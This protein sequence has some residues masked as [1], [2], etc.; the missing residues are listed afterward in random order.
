NIRLAS[1][2]IAKKNAASTGRPF[3]R[4]IVISSCGSTGRVSESVARLS[5]LVEMDIFDFVFCFAGVSTVDSIVVPALSRFVENVFVYDMG[6]WAALE[7]SF[8]EDKHALNTTPVMLSFAEFSKRPDDTR[9]RVVNTRVLAYSNFKDARPWGFDIYRCSNPTCGAHA[10][11]MIFHADGRQ[12]YGIRW[13]E[14]K[15]KTTCMKC[16][17]TRRKIAAPSWIHSCRAENIG[18]CW[19]QWPLTLAQRMDLGITH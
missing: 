19:Y 13:L 11:D 5:R 15:M 1:Q 7:R 9:D 6:L 10:H 2:E 14:A 12:Y 8:G 18:R 3:I 17:Q 16:Q 4:G